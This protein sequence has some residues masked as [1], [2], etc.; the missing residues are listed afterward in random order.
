MSG[1]EKGNPHQ[2]IALRLLIQ[3]ALSCLMRVAHQA[4]WR[5]PLVTLT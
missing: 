5:L 4:I 3:S 1:K 2:R